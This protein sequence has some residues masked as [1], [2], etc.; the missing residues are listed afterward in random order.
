MNCRFVCP[1]CRAP[2]EL[3]NENWHCGTCGRDYPILWGIPDF[4]LGP[5]RYLSL[6]DERAKAARLHNFARDHS[7][8]ETLDE[9][10]R[11]TDDVP[12]D[13]ARR[14]ADYVHAGEAR[15]RLVLDQLAP[16]TGNLLDIGCGAGGLLMAAARTG[17]GA[18]G[19]DIALRWLVIARKRL[20]EAGL[21]ADLVCADIYALPFQDAGYDGIAATDLFEHLADQPRAAKILRQQLASGGRLFATAANQFCLTPHP[22]AGLWGVG[23]LP[24]RFRSRYLIWR[25]GIDALRHANLISPRKLRDILRQ[26]G[27]EKLKLAPISVPV[28]DDIYRTRLQNT[29]IWL[30]TRLRR[31]PFVRQLMLMTG[32]AFEISAQAA[33][34]GATDKKT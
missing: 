28:T 32:P 1:A 26:S 13:M 2:L 8:A 18:T 22:L 29:A 27:M 5:D 6:A 15:G 4:R 14:F 3:A 33:G 9:Y 7:F 24:P 16:E 11:I 19:V 12:P 21:D 17:G 31:L 25:R 10:Y 30:Y 20:D 23:F 34:S